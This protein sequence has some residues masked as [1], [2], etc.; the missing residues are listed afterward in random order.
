MPT[1]SVRDIPKSLYERLRERAARHR[2]SMSGEVVVILE[3]I[4]A[5]RAIDVEELI[6]EAEEVHALFPEPLPDR[7]AEAKRDRPYED[8]LPDNREAAGG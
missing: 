8:D 1:L 4:L 2:R 5:P 6:R 3:Q 7:T